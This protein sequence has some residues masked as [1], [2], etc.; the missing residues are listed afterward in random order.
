MWIRR[1]RRMGKHFGNRNEF[2]KLMPP[3][4]LLG[5]GFLVTIKSSKRERAW[6]SKR[7]KEINIRIKC[8]QSSIIDHRKMSHFCNGIHCIQLIDRLIRGNH[9]LKMYTFR[10]HFT[11]SLFSSASAAAS[12]R[13]YRKEIYYHLA[14]MKQTDFFQ[15]N[16][17]KT[18]R[19]KSNV[20]NDGDC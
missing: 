4:K 14:R 16:S 7:E 8:N 6:V 3:N 2:V 5:F 18:Q 19:E 10:N 20:V 9:T 15:M 17:D 1:R 13:W 12:F 11:L